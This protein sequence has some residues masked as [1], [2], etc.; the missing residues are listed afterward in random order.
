MAGDPATSSIV[1]LRAGS[2]PATTTE[3]A[4]VTTTD[5]EA[6]GD[7]RSIEVQP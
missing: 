2:T 3:A 6:S 7:L 4:H 5:T 1:S